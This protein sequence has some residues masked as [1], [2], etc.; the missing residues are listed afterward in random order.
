MAS[1]LKTADKNYWTAPRPHRLLVRRHQRT[2]RKHRQNENSAEQGIDSA[3][4]KLLKIYVMRKVS[5][6]GNVDLDYLIFA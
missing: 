1:E 6:T 5:M 3:V 4:V 2:E